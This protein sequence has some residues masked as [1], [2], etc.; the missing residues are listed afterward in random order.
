MLL[1]YKR[2]LKLTLLLS[3][4]ILLF[5]AGMLDGLPRRSEIVAGL[6]ADPIQ[7]AVEMT[8]IV[9]RS[10]EYE[11]TIEPLYSYE[12][13]G[14]N[15][16][17]YDSRSWFD[18]A[19]RNDPFNTNDLC[20]IWGDDVR[21]ELYDRVEF[22]H[23]EFTCYFQTKDWEVFRRFN[24][25]QL[26]N[27]HV[28][29]ADPTVYDTVKRMRIGDQVALGG[30]LVNMKISGPGGVTGNR[31]TSTIR[32]DTGNGACEVMYVTSARIL[33]SGQPILRL[34]NDLAYYTLITSLSLTVLT[35]IIEMFR[36]YRPVGE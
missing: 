29:P 31:N 7:S 28:I 17:Q 27:T 13:R 12:I 8:P 4:G 30:Y 10:G 6:E 36:G 1:W 32:E 18:F 23:G 3:L 24:Q 9:V 26:S 25:A 22:S 34:L 11:A 19:H 33:R 2:L 20:L 15:V 21:D 16:A 5:A 14:L 35:F